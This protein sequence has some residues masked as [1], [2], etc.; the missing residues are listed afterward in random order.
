MEYKV[1]APFFSCYAN[2]A[3]YV[4][5]ISVRQLCANQEKLLN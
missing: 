1:G 4:D 5:V 3:G 2:R